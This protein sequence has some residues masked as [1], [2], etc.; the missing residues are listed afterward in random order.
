VLATSPIA[1]KNHVTVR[2]NKVITPTTSNH[3]Y[4]FTVGRNPTSRAMI[5]TMLVVRRL[6][7]ILATTCP[8]ITFMLRMGIVLNRSI[9][10]FVISVDTSTASENSINCPYNGINKI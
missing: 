7:T 8:V 6:R 3:E 1:A 10:P 4:I 9:I 5:M 2:I